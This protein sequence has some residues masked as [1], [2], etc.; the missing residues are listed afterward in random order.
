[1]AKRKIEYSEPEDFF[2]KAKFSGP[3]PM[4]TF[5]LLRSTTG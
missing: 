5:I 3:F 1:M 2:P 4:A